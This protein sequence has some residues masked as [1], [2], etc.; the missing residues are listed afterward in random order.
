[1]TAW[2]A[3]DRKA[4]VHWLGRCRTHQ[5][6]LGVY[7]ESWQAL[8]FEVSSGRTNH[9]ARLTKDECVEFERRMTRRHATTG[10]AS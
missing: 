7:D 9:T 3:E 5:M 2:K 1:M 8:A 10:R 6:E 4:W